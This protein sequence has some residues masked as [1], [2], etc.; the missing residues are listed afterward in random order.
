MA[1]P[2]NSYRVFVHHE[3][4]GRDALDVLVINKLKSTARYLLAKHGGFNAS[5]SMVVAPTGGR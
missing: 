5:I 2:V 1:T 4:P 3:K